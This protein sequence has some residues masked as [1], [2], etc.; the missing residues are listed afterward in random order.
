[1]S[2]IC[3]LKKRRQFALVKKGELRKGPFFSLKVLNN[4][5]SNLLP[6]VGFTVTKKQGCAV[7]RNRMRRRL[8]EAVRLCAEG[9]LKHG[10][11]YVLIAKRDA[12]FIPFK[13][14]CNHFVER[15]RRNKRSY[16]S[17]KNF[18]RKS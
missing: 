17:G 12:L 3:I 10:H 7:E 5:N 16:Y 15:V 18:S 6:R 11:D 4:N 1:M 2:N 8:K 9:V 14:L 13:E